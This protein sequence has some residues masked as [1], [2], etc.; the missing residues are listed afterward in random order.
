MRKLDNHL[1]TQQSYGINNA[2]LEADPQ[3]E[4]MAAEATDFGVF[5]RLIVP[6]HNSWMRAVGATTGYIGSITK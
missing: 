3:F 1:R 5:Q 4:K 6:P 2:L